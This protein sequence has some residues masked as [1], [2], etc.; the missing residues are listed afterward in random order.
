M[1]N[2]FPIE[3]FIVCT[4]SLCFNSFKLNFAASLNTS[5]A[6][7]KPQSTAVVANPDAT[8]PVSVETISDIAPEIEGEDN[9]RYV[10]GEVTSISITP[11]EEGMIDVL[12]I[13]GDTPAVLTL[14]DGVLVPEWFDA[15]SL[16][17]NCVYEINILDGVYATVLFWYLPVEESELNDNLSENLGLLT[18]FPVIDINDR[19]DEEIGEHIEAEDSEDEDNEVV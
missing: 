3:Y 19:M 6:T 4:S 1:F 18:D 15:T 7:A 17:S 5:L 13:S 10:C 14:G 12:F 11:P 2:I 16:E 9:V 8:V